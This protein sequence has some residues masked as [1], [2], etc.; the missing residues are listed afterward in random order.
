M[1]CSLAVVGDGGGGG[2]GAGG[3]TLLHWK[4]CFETCSWIEQA[5]RI[6]FKKT[7]SKQWM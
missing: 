1:F 2:S 6:I 3:G 7:E 4:L 5:E